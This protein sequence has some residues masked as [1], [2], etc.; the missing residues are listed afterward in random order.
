[1]RYLLLITGIVFRFFI[2]GNAQPGLADPFMWG[3]ATYF[4]LSIGE[5]IIYRDSEIELLGIKNHFNHLRVNNDTL[6]IKVSYRTPATAIGNLLLFVADNRNVAALDGNN[7]VH[8]LLK[9]DALVVVCPVS[10]PLLDRWTYSFPVSFTDGYIWKNEEDSYMFSYQG[11]GGLKP[12]RYSLFPG[13]GLGMVNARLSGKHAILAMESGRVAWVERGRNDQGQP[14]ASICIE[15][16]SSP[17]IY[18]LYHN[19][20]DKSVAV[21]KNQKVEKGDPLGHIW[22]D[23]NWEYLRMVVVKSDTMPIPGD[24]DPNLVNFFPQL[25]ELY[26]GRQPNS[27]TVFTKGKISFGKPTGQKDNIKNASAFEEYLGTGWELGTWNTA[28][29][30]EWVSTR[31]NGNVRLTEKLFEGQPAHCINPHNWYEFTINVKNGIYRIRA[32]VGDIQKSSWQKIEF[33]GVVAGIYQL[34]P[35]QF[36]WTSEKIVRVTDGKLTTRIWLGGEGQVAAI[37]EI[38]FQ[39]ASL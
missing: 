20:V 4:N 36:I 25:L 7:A 12:G 19:M 18:Y 6:W 34:D 39:Q 27:A 2:S 28:D 13:I 8:G 23:G 33:E 30:V 15:S 38:V 16:R 17:G 11:A 26:Y 22:G 31:Q 1:M 9:K 29:K 35:N 37:S 10:S 21:N 24:S 5:K 32:L 3:N 14:K